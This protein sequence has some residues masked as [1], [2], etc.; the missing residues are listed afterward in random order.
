MITRQTRHSVR[1][2]SLETGQHPKKLRKL[3]RAAGVIGS[4]QMAMSDHNV[5]FDAQA[6]T[7]AVSTNRRRLYLPAA[8]AYLNAPRV[9]ADLLVKHGFIKP[10]SPVAG[11][12][13]QY[14]IDDL[15]AFLGKLTQ[16]AKPL[17]R[18]SAAVAGIQQAARRACC[19]AADIVRMILE[20][21]LAWAGRLRGVHG[22]QSV[23]VKIDE[24]KAAV[25]GPEHGGLTHRE[26][27]EALRTNYRVVLALIANGHLADFRAPNPVNRRMQSLVAS[28]ELERFQKTYVS[29]HVLAKERERH[30]VALKKDFEVAGVRSAFDYKKIGARFYRRSEC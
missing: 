18:P 30:N 11:T 12:Y 22:Y 20:R 7:A 16:G 15:D 1:T 19:S 25:R 6:G 9:Q 2:L 21:Q 23:L 24:V 3:L 8:R 17:D 10:S 14:A 5:T 4:D 13:D 29:L 26:V 28:S 27:R